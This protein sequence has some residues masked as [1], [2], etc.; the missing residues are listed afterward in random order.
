MSDWRCIASR[1]LFSERSSFHRLS[2]AAVS[3]L[4]VGYADNGNITSKSDAGSFDYTT[5][6]A[7]CSY[8]GLPAQPHAVRKA[9]SIVYCYDKNG[10]MVARGGSTISWYSYNQPNLINAGSNSSQFNYN[11]N[12]QRWK[13]VAVDGTGT[14]TTWYVGGILEKLSRPGGVI[15]YRHMIPAGSGMAIYLRKPDGT[16]STTYVTT[17][18]LGSGD[19][20]LDSTANVLARESFTPFGARRGSN[21]TGTPTSGDYTTFSNTTRRGFTGHEMLDAVSLVNMNGRVY[22]PLIGR[23]LS[24]DPIVQTINL[25]QA[26]NPYSYVMNMPL[27]LT[28]PSGYSWLSSLFHSIG[29]FLKKWGAM[30]VGVVMTIMGQPWYWAV[31]AS[32]AFGAAVSG[33]NF[34][35]GFVT[36]VIIGTITAGIGNKIGLGGWAAKVVGDTGSGLLNA[37][38]Q[39]A[40]VGALTG[41]VVSAAMGGSFWAGFTGGALA[42]AVA[43]AMTWA[44]KNYLSP[45]GTDRDQ[46][47]MSDEE[48][49]ARIQN[50]IDRFKS[51]NPGISATF[52]NDY[53]K[54][55]VSY[56]VGDSRTF[57]NCKE[58]RAFMDFKMAR[59]ANPPQWVD[60]AVSNFSNG[61]VHVYATFA[62][63]HAGESIYKL[64]KPTGDYS[65]AE[66]WHEMGHVGVRYGGGGFLNGGFAGWGNCS[67]AGCEIDATRWAMTHSH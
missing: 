44:A 53:D 13:Q 22:D 21:W 32:S 8:S 31:I 52:E 15:E 40:L 43:G 63:D 49:R 46:P 38:L 35:Q 10:N 60:A 58:A 28:D 67:S 6:Q 50:S 30:I 48:R 3:D 36:G 45:K 39:G 64:W 25:S 7:G 41:G 51:E 65:Q 61:T 33:G 23:F 12:H 42:G 54:W 2:G 20:I 26:L 24:A 59:S 56:G 14:T 11:A 55:V 1:G 18:H 5:Q 62:W 17:D 16:N 57:D 66:L 19:L 37:A 34:I 9:G 29:H 27:T 4:T 47:N